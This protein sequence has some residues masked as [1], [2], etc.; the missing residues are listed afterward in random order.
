[1]RTERKFAHGVQIVP[2]WRSPHH[3]HAFRE[4]LERWFVDVSED[5]DQS[6]WFVFTDGLLVHDV[7][8][9]DLTT[10]EGVLELGE[11][12]GFEWLGSYADALLI[13]SPLTTWANSIGI[14]HPGEPSSRG[15]L[16]DELP[17]ERST[18]H[19]RCVR[20]DRPAAGD[21]P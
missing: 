11:K 20:Q 4:S 21:G 2:S 3:F 8:A 15:M 13:E 1:M 16:G 19:P 6:A 14:A 7:A 18:V 5:S 9:A 10:A 17:G 12:I